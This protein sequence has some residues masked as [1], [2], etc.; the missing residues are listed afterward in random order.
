MPFLWNPGGHTI[1]IKRNMTIGYVKAKNSQIDQK[2]N[3]RE[4]SIIL[5]EKLPPMPEKPIFIIHHRFE[6][7]YNLTR[8]M[9]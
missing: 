9:T 6:T 4:V 3:V 8:N 7:C 5:Q 2:E 1:T